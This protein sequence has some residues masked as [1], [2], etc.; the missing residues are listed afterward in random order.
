MIATVA[1]KEFLEMTRDGRFRAAAGLVLLLLVAALAA[2]WSRHDEVS[3]AHRAAMNRERSIW[4]SQGEKSPHSAAHYGVYAFKPTGPLAFADPGTEAYT[5]VTVWLEAH[6]QNDF[7]YRPARDATALQRFG[8]LTAATVMQLLVPLLIVLMVFPAFAGEREAGTL[9]QLL[10][11]GVDRRTLLAGKALGLALALA[12][13]LV[14]AASIGGLAMSA[15]AAD[16]AA[17]D[18]MARGGLLALVYVLYFGVFAAVSLAV[19]AWASS[20]R[21]ALIALLGFWIFGCLA[22]PRAA[23]DWAKRVHPTPSA[24][25]FA[26]AM[27]AEMEK[28]LDGVTFTEFKEAK[29]RELLAEHGVSRVED[30]PINYAGWSLEIGEQYG[31]QFFDKHYAALW[32][33][34]ERQDRLRQA[35]GLAAPLLAARSLSMGLAGTDFPHF[36]HFAEDAE[37]YRRT[38]VRYLNDDQRDHAGQ[39]D[40]G[41]TRDAEL[42][43]QVPAFE[44]HA[45]T[46]GW[47]L[48]RQRMALAALLAWFLAAS[49]LAWFSTRR[50]RVI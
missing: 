28:G 47:A 20:A 8:E 10:S 19:S 43:T 39:R 44:Y 26:A 49:A 11:L 9:R 6:K 3:R 41:Y 48:A 45:P 22:L 38:F 30:L 33:S 35:A 31:N 27:A 23:T 2:G 50:L 46:L 12:A 4:E 25:E 17:G 7:L 5:G 32:D 14:P 34:F 1:R 13:L 16:A 36:R 18:L 40:F 24:L 29:E 15:A 37:I 42:W 21:L